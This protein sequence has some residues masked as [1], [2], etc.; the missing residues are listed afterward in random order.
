MMRTL[1][2]ATCVMYS[3]VCFAEEP[4]KQPD[5]KAAEQKVVAPSEKK[6]ID[7]SGDSLIAPSG[8]GAWSTL[9]SDMKLMTVGKDGQMLVAQ[10]PAVGRVAVGHK[11]HGL[12]LMLP[13]AEDWKFSTDEAFPVSCYSPGLGVSITIKAEAAKTETTAT[14]CMMTTKKKV[15]KELGEVKPQM[16]K[17]NFEDPVLWR[18]EVSHP[19]LKARNLRQFNLW[20]FQTKGNYCY[21][22]RMSI[23]TDHSPKRDKFLNSV[24]KY[25]AT[26]KTTLKERVE[27][28]AK[29]KKALKKKETPLD[30]SQKK[31]PQSAP[32]T[33]PADASYIR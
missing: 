22:Y 16:E 13:Y 24:I 5:S 20:N 26:F 28:A 9:A 14:Q 18:Y 31:T 1:I 11:V 32:A 12:E 17:T 4:A 25:V 8:D 27:K 15:V 10:F 33:A 23:L 29:E 19:E 21:K 7:M 2:I 30:N 3:I 6:S